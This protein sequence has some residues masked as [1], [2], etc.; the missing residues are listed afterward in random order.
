M[1]KSLG[2]RNKIMV[3]TKRPNT[4]VSNS[5]LIQKKLNPVT[6]SHERIGTFTQYREFRPG[7]VK[8]S[9]EYNLDA[10]SVSVGM[11]NQQ[12]LNLDKTDWTN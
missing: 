11:N 3:S 6:S 4:S 7:K 10:N 9:F 5:N 2:S 8:R 12:I 1:C